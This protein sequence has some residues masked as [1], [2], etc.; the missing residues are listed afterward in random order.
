MLAQKVS[1]AAQDIRSDPLRTASPKV[2]SSHEPGEWTLCE[3]EVVT[4]PIRNFVTDGADR[5]ISRRSRWHNS[6]SDF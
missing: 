5:R 3:P 4:E 2:V 6:L 1:I